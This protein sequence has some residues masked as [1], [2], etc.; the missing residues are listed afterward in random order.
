MLGMLLAALDQTIVATALPTIV[1]DLGGLDHLVVGRHRLPAGRDRR[2]RRCTAS[3]ATS[4][5]ASACSRSR[6]SSSW[7][8]ACCRGLAQT[9]GQLI[10]FRAVQGLGAGGLIVLAQ[11]IIADVVSPRERGRYQGYFGAVFGAASVAGPLLGGFLTDHLSWR[12]VFYVNVP[13]GIVALVVTSAVL[14]AATQRRQRPHRLGRRRPAR[15]PPSPASCCSPPGAAPSTTW[16]SPMIVGLG[17]AAV[18]ARGRL[19]RRRAPGAGAGASRCG[20]SAS[21]RSPS[22]SAISFIIGVAMF[23][24]DHLPADRSCRSSTAPRPPTRACCSCR[25]WSAC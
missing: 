16:G 1:G 24:A 12:W 3:S 10:A 9:M 6:S 21:A 17:V 15:R 20:C 14:P 4:T 2:R 25:S 7:S 13:L 18:V 11:A 23:G 5:A 19:R 22:P 8:A